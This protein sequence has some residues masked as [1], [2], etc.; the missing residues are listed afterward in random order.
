MIFF[1]EGCDPCILGQTGMEVR[2]SRASVAEC[3]RRRGPDTA[4]LLRGRGNPVLLVEADDPWLAL[5]RP[6]VF[7]HA[8]GGDDHHGPMNLGW[9]HDPMHS[10]L[11]DQ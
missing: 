2:R 8:E 7:D 5:T 9:Q 1:L 6:R 11:S 4:N 3:P 10:C